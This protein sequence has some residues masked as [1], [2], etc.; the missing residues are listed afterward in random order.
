MAVAEDSCCNTSNNPRTTNTG[1]FQVCRDIEGM[2][3]AVLFT[4]TIAHNFM[5]S[6]MTTEPLARSLA[7]ISFLLR[8][9]DGNGDSRRNK[10]AIRVFLDLR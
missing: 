3:T 4:W 9:P 2:H 5:H 6:E 7:Q 10:H 1:E 8:L